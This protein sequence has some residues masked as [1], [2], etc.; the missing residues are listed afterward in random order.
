MVLDAEETIFGAHV[1]KLFCGI[2]FLDFPSI[3]DI[4][5]IL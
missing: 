5:Y 2:S 1:A 3:P 4:P